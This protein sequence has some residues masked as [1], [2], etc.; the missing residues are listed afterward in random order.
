MLCECV[1]V[2]VC[3]CCVCIYVCMYTCVS[4]SIPKNNK[5]NETENKKTV[6]AG[7]L[8]KDK[9]KCAHF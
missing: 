4:I 8:T 6:L 5:C 2:C 9:Y 7:M 3:I 1:S